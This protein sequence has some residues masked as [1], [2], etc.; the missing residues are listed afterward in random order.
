MMN[1]DTLSVNVMLNP[2]ITKDRSGCDDNY[3]QQQ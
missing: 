1:D 2:S 3:E